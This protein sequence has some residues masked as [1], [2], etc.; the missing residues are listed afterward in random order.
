MATFSTRQAAKQLS[1]SAGTLSEYIS[2]KKI[3]APTTIEVGG[4]HVHVWT[5]DHIERVRELLPK[6]KNGRKTRWSKQREEEQK[7]RKQGQK[8][9][10]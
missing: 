8:K 4:R 5:A 9:E 3:P 10:S 7:N 1:L 2:A 6:I